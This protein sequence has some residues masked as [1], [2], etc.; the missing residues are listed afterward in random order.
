[1]CRGE[2]GQQPATASVQDTAIEFRPWCLSA[3][4]PSSSPRQTPVAQPICLTPCP[5]HIIDRH[6]QTNVSVVALVNRLRLYRVAKA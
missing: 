1:M 3:L 4:W 5:H 2:G 6:T